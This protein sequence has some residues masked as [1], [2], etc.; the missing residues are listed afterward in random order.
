[1]DFAMFMTVTKR[2]K[3]TAEIEKIKVSNTQP[4]SVVLND[5]VFS[6]SLLECLL[7]RY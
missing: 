1:M 5:L 4:L 6:L 3:Y 2:G 7:L